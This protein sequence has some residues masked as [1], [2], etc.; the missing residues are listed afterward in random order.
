LRLT[1]QPVIEREDGSRFTAEAVEY[2]RLTG[3]ISTV[4]TVRARVESPDGLRLPAWPGL[5]GAP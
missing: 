2:H 5:P 1:G 3:V 4:G